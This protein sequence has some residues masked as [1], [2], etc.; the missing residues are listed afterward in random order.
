MMA[1][2]T[3]KIF[4]RNLPF[5]CTNEQL[6]AAYKDNGPIKN[7]FVVRDKGSTERCRG[8]GFVTFALKED[9][10]KAVT[11][12]KE[13]GGRKL[14]AAFANKKPESKQAREPHMRQ[15]KQSSNIVK[16]KEKDEVRIEKSEQDSEDEGEKSEEEGDDESGEVED[17][18][19]D[20]DNSDD[21][22]DDDRSD[23]TD[24]EDDD[25]DDDSDDDSKGD[26]DNGHDDDDGKND[27]DMEVEGE[28]KTQQD[29]PQQQ[30][31]RGEKRK[32]VEEGSANEMSKK[33]QK[34]GSERKITV[35]NIELP[36]YTKKLMNQFQMFGRVTNCYMVPNNKEGA[37]SMGCAVI[38]FLREESAKKALSYEKP[39]KYRGKPVTVE[40][41]ESETTSPDS[42]VK[43][44]GFRIIVRNLS[45]RCTEV[46]LG[47]AFAEFGKVL[48]TTIPSKYVKGQHRKMGFGFVRYKTEEEAVAA[49]SAMNG[50]EIIGRPVAV[51][52]VKPRDEYR[53]LKQDNVKGINSK[54][55]TTK[56]NQK[57]DDGGKVKGGMENGDDASD[58][59]EEETGNDESEDEDDESS[60]EE[61]DGDDSMEEEETGSD[62]DGDDDSEKEEE[63]EEKQKEE[64][65]EE[66]D[67]EEE[68]EEDKKKKYQSDRASMDI[69][70]G[71]TVFVRNLP[72]E[73]EQKEVESL[74]SKFGAIKYC[75]LVRDRMTGLPR[76]SAF[77]Q[78]ANPTEAQ[79][80]LTEAVKEDN[81]LTLHDR[82]L[83][84]AKAL[85]RDK[86]SEVQEKRKKIERI[87]EKDK[88]N[89]YLLMEGFIRPGTEA[90][91]GLTES[92]LRKRAKVEAVKRA[93][94]KNMFIFVSKT[95]LV[96]HNLPRNV[97]DKKLREV[98]KSAVTKKGAKVLEAKVMRDTSKVG[99][100]GQ[101]KS[102]GYGFVSFSDHQH[103]L[104]ALRAV[105]NNPDY[106]GA[107]KRPIV[108][109]SLENKKALEKREWRK[110]RSKETQSQ[111]GAKSQQQN[112][113]NT[114]SVIDVENDPR[115]DIKGR[116]GLTTHANAKMRWRDRGKRVEEAR[117]MKKV[118][119]MKFTQQQV[120]KK[121]S[122]GK[123]ERVPVNLAAVHEKT[124][125]KRR[126]GRKG[127]KEEKRFD[128]L[129]A[130]Y[131]EKF[132]ESTMVKKSKWFE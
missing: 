111:K 9:A 105:N 90:A 30:E 39:I 5:T 115:A 94:I 49:I 4:V 45:F 19:D 131:K 102:L 20:N 58:D 47:D 59:E 51:D 71:R 68:E 13:I 62:E 11:E 80:C 55:N 82:Q 106:F 104:E 121:E 64:E 52:W 24:S 36:C 107:D 108:G 29:I 79:K 117:R 124:N 40:K 96:V 113:K 37:S 72:F 54:E 6:E 65:K 123:M 132:S 101:G 116:K 53:K 44:Q 66:D 110:Q 100:N 91:K 86:A 120:A 93:K 95:R 76:G 43:D 41:Y 67:D 128:S 32:S 84:V 97:N 69:E 61:E 28:V 99:E 130:Q 127:F 17:K 89:T 18:A 25:D 112:K 70:E 15:Q 56:G 23:D 35:K 1:K 98:F 34:V 31:R 50:K 74:F 33:K 16:M 103:A 122:L 81:S 21:Y 48:E 109:F 92:D 75:A 88:R 78:Y 57:N 126:R 87:E 3:N 125:P 42:E 85:S 8:I 27:E 83:I 119:R 46:Q 10:E 60:E 12:R 26:D 14:Q 7:C 22:D 63:K 77:V 129:V 114:S 2:T 38:V 118:K 73:V